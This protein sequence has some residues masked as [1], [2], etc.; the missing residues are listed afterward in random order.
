MRSKLRVFSLLAVALVAACCPLFAHH[1]NASYDT[2]KQITVTGTVT[3]FVWANPHVYLRMDVKDESGSIQ[4]WVIEGQNAVTQAN[5]GWTKDMFKPGDQVSIGAT[6]AKN[7]RQIG[8]F[9]GSIVIN[10][11]LFKPLD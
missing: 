8:R 2:S 3:E 1:G 9:K 10:G 4:H 5:A 7:G 11:K 6:P